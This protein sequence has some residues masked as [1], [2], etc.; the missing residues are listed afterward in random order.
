[1]IEMIQI[2]RSQQKYRAQL[3]SL[4]EYGPTRA[5]AQRRLLEA[6][7]EALR[8]AGR[9]SIFLT[10]QHVGI[11]WYEPL[12]RTWDYAYVPRQE[13][14]RREP[15]APGVEV[16]A[17]SSGYTSRHE[18]EKAARRHIAQN[19]WDPENPA[20]AEVIL[21]GDPEGLSQHRSWVEWQLRYQDARR[22]GMSDQ[23]AFN[24]AWGR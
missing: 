6:A 23:E 3:G 4:I 14:E 19:E 22:Q 18:A 24:H 21:Q 13:L 20:A 8:Y 17:I 11:V 2:G 1:V 16:R 5:E 9:P 15:G 10:P 12:G 7:A